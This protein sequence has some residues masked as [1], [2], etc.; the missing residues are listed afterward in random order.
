MPLLLCPPFISLLLQSHLALSLDALFPTSFLST[1]VCTSVQ[2]TVSDG[3]S[4]E[5]YLTQGE[6][7][8]INKQTGNTESLS[9][10][11]LKKK[12][13]NKKTLMRLG[14]GGNNIITI[15]THLFLIIHTKPGLC[16]I[17]LRFLYDFH[18]CFSCYKALPNL[19][20]SQKQNI[21]SW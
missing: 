18:V 17:R 16:V 2:W 19:I 15:F 14:V 8:Y 6:I 7:F 13:R 1:L 11:I 21:K 9:S 4:G 12:K 5:S 10:Y 3:P 20:H